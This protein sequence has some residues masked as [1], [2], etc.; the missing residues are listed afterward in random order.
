[1]RE[2]IIPEFGAA[3]RRRRGVAVGAGMTNSNSCCPPTRSTILASM[4]RR[5][6]SG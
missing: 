5:G 2:K 1:V 6:S 4:A 3:N